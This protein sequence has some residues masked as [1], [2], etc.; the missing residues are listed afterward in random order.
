MPGPTKAGNSS[1]QESRLLPQRRQHMFLIL[2]F[3]CLA[4]ILNDLTRFGLGTPPNH[5][6]ECAHREQPPSCCRQNQAQACV[7]PAAK[8]KTDFIRCRSLIPCVRPSVLTVND[9]LPSAVFSTRPRTPKKGCSAMSVACRGRET[10]RRSSTTTCP[11]QSLPLPSRSLRKQH[12]QEAES[13]V[14]GSAQVLGGTGGC[15]VLIPHG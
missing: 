12:R 1:V 9:M 8:S 3:R 5:R 7:P 6:A 2:G 13:F 11:H 14:C 10:P 4:L 15:N